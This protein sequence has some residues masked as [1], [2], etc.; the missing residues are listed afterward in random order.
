M[1]GTTL[2]LFV[3]LFPVQYMEKRFAL[4]AR[5]IMTT[6]VARVFEFETFAHILLTYDKRQEKRKKSNTPIGYVPTEQKEAC[7]HAPKGGTRETTRR[8]KNATVERGRNIV[9]KHMKRVTSIQYSIHDEITR[10]LCKKKTRQLSCNRRAKGAH[11]TKKENTKDTR[12]SRTLSYKRP[13]AHFPEQES[14]SVLSPIH[15]IKQDLNTSTTG[16]N[17]FDF[18]P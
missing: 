11:S 15:E 18:I 12:A 13:Q 7:I 8:H 2:H 14:P 6:Q 16:A 4:E 5:E 1:H 17:S 3:I 9:R 10:A